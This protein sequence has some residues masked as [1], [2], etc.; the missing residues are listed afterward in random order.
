MRTRYD[1]DFEPGSDEFW[2][3]SDEL[4]DRFMS[5]KDDHLEELRQLVAATGGPA[6]DGSLESLKAVEQ[7]FLDVTSGPFDDG[8]DWMPVWLPPVG[9]VS[10]TGLSEAVALRMDE[11]VG[12]YYGEVAISELE[13]SQWVCWRAQRAYDAG[14]GWVALDVGRYPSRLDPLYMMR[15]IR[16]RHDP[17]QP[18][19]SLSLRLY[20]ERWKRRDYIKEHGKLNFQVAPAGPEAGKGRGATRWMRSDRSRIRLGLT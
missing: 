13:G 15:L 5:A 12:I 16:E 3:A 4:F 18:G 2:A 17:G 1:V 10:K 9:E 11:R 14:S 7:W 20:Q 19:A 6:L 8:A